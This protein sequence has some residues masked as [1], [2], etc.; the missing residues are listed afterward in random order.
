MY[1]FVA[2]RRGSA[3]DM[4][5][6]SD[7][8][9]AASAPA[10]APAATATSDPEA[11]LSKSARKRLLKVE[12]KESRKE[13]RKIR[14]EQ[15]KEKLAA[16][17]AERAAG[18][19]EP[20]ILCR[21]VD[22]NADTTTFGPEHAARAR[23]F[24]ATKL[25]SPR[26]VLAPMVNQSELAFRL[27]ARRRG[28]TLC[29]TPMLHSRRF[30]TEQHYRDENFEVNA[31]DRPLVAQFCGDD[32]ATMLAAALHAQPNCDAI[33]INCGCPQAIAQRG[34]YGAFLLDEP[35]LIATLVSTLAR[36]AHARRRAHHM[37]HARSPPVAP[38]DHAP[39]QVW[40]H[41]PGRPQA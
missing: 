31:S 4:L 37:R 38:H 34:H 8:P 10:P 11:A 21:P 29:Y 41:L 6:G 7:A 33:D 1:E 39:A 32:P 9:S 25:G 28:F 36:G 3:A 12:Q 13:W 30:A 15:R 20:V 14:K 17:A 23:D 22:N 35:E 40:S 5:E 18:G 19:P 26:L 27:L 24:F 2:R 16:I